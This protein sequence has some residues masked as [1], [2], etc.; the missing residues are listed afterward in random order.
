[1]AKKKESDEER[2]DRIIRE[3]QE[4][5]DRYQAVYDEEEDMVCY[6]EFTPEFD[7]EPKKQLSE[8]YVSFTL[9]EDM[10]YTIKK[11]EN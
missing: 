4:A 7:I 6:I 8:D 2:R 9:N 5:G 11:Q 3:A 10:T 1:M